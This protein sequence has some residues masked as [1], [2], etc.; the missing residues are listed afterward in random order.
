MPRVIAGYFSDEAGDLVATPLGTAATTHGKWGDDCH[1]RLPC[2]VA[3]RE[4]ELRSEAGLPR[5]AVAAPSR[6]K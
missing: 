5:V 6:E 3:L 2:A 1:A 4:R